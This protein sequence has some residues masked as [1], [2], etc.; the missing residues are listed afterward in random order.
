MQ[1]WVSESVILTFVF[2][3]KLM[4]LVYFDESMSVIDDEQQWQLFDFF[5]LATII[6]L[7]ILLWSTAVL[8]SIAPPVTSQVIILTM[9][10]NLHNCMTPSPWC[11]CTVVP[12]IMQCDNE[13][14]T[15]FP[16]PFTVLNNTVFVIWCFRPMLDG[17]VNLDILIFREL[18]FKD[19]T[20]TPFNSFSSGCETDILLSAHSPSNHQNTYNVLCWH[21]REQI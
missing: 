1:L 9:T 3:V 15:K 17:L 21:S 16:N 8:L 20:Y 13:L 12:L 18:N 19:K 5:P 6:I 2:K 10:D 7:I 11:A 14:N 4:D